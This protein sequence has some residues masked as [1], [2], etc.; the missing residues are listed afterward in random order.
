MTGNVVSI[1]ASPLSLPLHVLFVLERLYT[2][3]Y[4]EN[5]WHPLLNANQDTKSCCV[6]T[7]VVHGCEAGFN[8]VD[9]AVERFEHSLVLV[10]VPF[11][12]KLYFL[13]VLVIRMIR[14][15]PFF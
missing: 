2:L 5:G 10:I 11:W 1:L 13:H 6:E 4:F 8:I 3:C 14:S 12:R 15:H 9:I 7:A